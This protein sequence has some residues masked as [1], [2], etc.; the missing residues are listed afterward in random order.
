MRE[1]RQMYLHYNGHTEGGAQLRA[2]ILETHIWP[3]C[4][5]IAA[6]LLSIQLCQINLAP[7]LRELQWQ[8]STPVSTAQPIFHS[9]DISHYNRSLGYRKGVR[10]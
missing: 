10:V 7:V 8:Y 3:E 5:T 9:K 6:K 2:G 1:T 4:K